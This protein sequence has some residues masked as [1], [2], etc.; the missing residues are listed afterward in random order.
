MTV[1][2]LDASAAVA[3]LASPEGFA[4]LPDGEW[5]A[6]PLLWS[7]VAS[8]LHRAVVREQ[9]SAGFGRAALDRLLAAPIHRRAP[10]R[11]L[12][13]AWS[14]ADTFDWSK[15]YDAEYIALARI[16]RCP[17][18]T[19]DLRQLRAASRLIEALSL[20]DIIG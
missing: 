15:T 10:A 6:P 11:L 16:D 12:R 7:G 5:T 3:I 18:V 1:R 9:V 14:I 20:T 17:L 19:A 4:A 8:V 2:V 13:E